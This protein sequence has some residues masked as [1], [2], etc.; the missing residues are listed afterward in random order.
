MPRHRRR[1]TTA[2]AGAPHLARP[3]DLDLA[4]Q[5]Q[6]LTLSL[7]NYNWDADPLI[8]T[9]ILTVNLCRR[10]R[11]R[12]NG[13]E[14]STFTAEWS[15]PVHRMRLTCRPSET[16]A[17]TSLPEFGMLSSRV[18]TPPFAPIFPRA[19]SHCILLQCCNRV[20]R[21]VENSAAHPVRELHLC[22]AFHRRP[23]RLCQADTPVPAPRAH[24]PRTRARTEKLPHNAVRVPPAAI[25]RTEMSPEK[26]NK[27]TSPPKAL[28]KDDR[29]SG[30][31]RRQR[32]TCPTGEP[33]RAGACRGRA[34]RRPSRIAFCVV[35]QG[36]R[37]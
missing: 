16:L 25:Q 22:T 4:P 21:E 24:V 23:A 13:S 5:P 17:V 12:S 3:L 19:P 35:V 11:A 29:C 30:E 20:V 27:S 2:H 8:P 26:E 36:V 6:A 7:I 15:R 14:S 18:C 32:C 28:V 9:L 10:V 1:L 37:G 33:P 31:R 34:P